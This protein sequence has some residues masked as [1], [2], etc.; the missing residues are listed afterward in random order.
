MYHLVFVLMSTKPKE[1]PNGSPYKSQPGTRLKVERRWLGDV[2]RHLAVR[3]GV[4]WGEGL[5]FPAGVGRMPP[6]EARHLGAVWRGA[7]GVELRVKK[8]LLVL[9]LPLLQVH[10]FCLLENYLKL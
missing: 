4:E 1:Q 10:V 3:K 7:S 2:P 9:Q 8:L 6:R 5:E